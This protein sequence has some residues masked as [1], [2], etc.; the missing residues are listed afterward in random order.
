MHTLS[1]TIMPIQGWHLPTNN[2]QEI[3]PVVSTDSGSSCT[4]YSFSHFFHKVPPQPPPI[5]AGRA[6]AVSHR[7][8]PQQK[9]A[10][11]IFQPLDVSTNRLTAQTC[12]QLPSGGGWQLIFNSSLIKYQ[13][14]P[15]Y[16]LM[17]ITGGKWFFRVWLLYLFV[18][19]WCYDLAISAELI[20]M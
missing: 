14:I 1:A 18:C 16:Y 17:R 5:L 6:A 9:W 3:W 19:W 11:T 10:T 7:F 20:V 13:L 2:I 15:H 8:T 12:Q 4:E